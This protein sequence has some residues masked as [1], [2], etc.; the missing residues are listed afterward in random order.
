MLI[1]QVNLSSFY[2]LLLLSASFKL[3]LKAYSRGLVAGKNV[4]V[5]RL[6]PCQRL[7]KSE[8]Y[9]GNKQYIKEP[10]LRGNIL[11]NISKVG[12]DLLELK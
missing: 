2:K 1:C 3:F 10:F 4:M 9:V 5:W 12:D 7:F 11:L 6:I 8:E